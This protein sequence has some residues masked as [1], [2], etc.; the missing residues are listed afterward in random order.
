MFALLLDLVFFSSTAQRQQ[1]LNLFNTCSVWTA[2]FKLV[3]TRRW[4]TAVPVTD[5]ETSASA[6]R[7]NTTGQ[8]EAGANM[9]LLSETS[10]FSDAMACQIAGQIEGNV[11]CK[12]VSALAGPAGSVVCDSQTGVRPG[13]VVRCR[14]LSGSR[15]DQEACH[16]RPRAQA[17]PGQDEK[18]TEISQEGEEG[19]ST[20]ERRWPAAFQPCR[21]PDSL[22]RHGLGHSAPWTTSEGL[23]FL[24]GRPHVEGKDVAPPGQAMGTFNLLD[25]MDRE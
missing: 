24:T 5:S 14:P 25:S 17:S 21:R 15:D 4:R 6:P 8:K 23:H 13:E 7:K 18:I 2:Q 9:K 19:A 22:G 16:H 20:A 3:R 1:P 12:A 11:A 10:S